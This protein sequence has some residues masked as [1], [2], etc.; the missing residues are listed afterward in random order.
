MATAALEGVK[1]LD[2]SWV[3]SGPHATSCL[4]QFGATV[5]RIESAK[6]PDTLRYSAPYKDGIPGLNRSGHFAYYNTNKYSL[7][8]NLNLP[9]ALEVARRLVRW[10]D[11]VVENFIPGQ[12]EK[13][14]LG[15][16]GLT[17]IRPNVIFLRLSM[18]GQTGPRARHLGF[19]PFLAG[20]VGY[21]YLTGWPDRGPVLIGGPTDHLVP[22][23]AVAVLM[24]ALDYRDATGKG[25]CIDISQ[26]ETGLQA[27]APLMLHY[28]AS[29]EIGGRS[30]NFRP[31]AAPHGVYRCMGD[32]RWCAITVSTDDE[33]RS[34][35]SVVG[36]PDWTTDR[37]FATLLA[38]KRNEEELNTLVESWTLRHSAEEAMNLMQQ[39]G[40][41]AGIVATAGDLLRD[42][43]LGGRN[44]FW[45]MDHPELGPFYYLG[46]PFALSATPAQQRLPSPCLG[47]HT[48][49][50]C[51]EILGMSDAEFVA[52]LKK[53]VFE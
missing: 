24:A 10:C 3:A 34:F 28:F 43:Q 13:W 25:Q 2:F 38:R 6:R 22:D 9:E 20:L 15:Y 40:V 30:G 37:R 19:G 4:G 45:L 32:D 14:G 48:E 42:P 51:Q 49:Y 31:E 33:W 26:C 5:V 29:G 44:R 7:A 47:E 41:P 53:G 36:G 16:E 39:S 18:Y 21:Q 46:E 50:V 17:Q 12:M 52:L 1:V 35:C 23:Y 27:I 8:L 11:I